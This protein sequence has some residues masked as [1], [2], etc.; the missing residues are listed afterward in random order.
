MVLVSVGIL[1]YLFFN[2]KLDH[3]GVPWWPSSW[4]SGVVNAVTQ[5]RFLVCVPWVLPKK[6][7]FSG[8]PRLNLALFNSISKS[9][10]VTFLKFQCDHISDTNSRQISNFL[11]SLVFCL[12][13][14]FTP[15]ILRSSPLEFQTIQLPASR[16]Q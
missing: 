5:V 2:S 6:N 10:S 1:R 9:E 3:R 8:S 11:H 14:S 13:G 7:F 16:V 15:Y 4:V 12:S